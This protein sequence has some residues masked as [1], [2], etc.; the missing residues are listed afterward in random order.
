M[1]EHNN[2]EIGTFESD[3][4]VTIRKLLYNNNKNI[5]FHDV[6]QGI[7]QTDKPYVLRRYGYYP[8]LTPQNNAGTYAIV[9]RD[10]RD[11]QKKRIE[12][13][14]DLD[15][16]NFRDRV[17]E[18]IKQNAQKLP[19]EAKYNIEGLN[20]ANV[21]MRPVYGFKFTAFDHDGYT[22][23]IEVTETRNFLATTQGHHSITLYLEVDAKDADYIIKNPQE[24]K[25]V[26]EYSTYIVQQDQN[27]TTASI[28]DITKSNIYADLQQQASGK[29]I[30]RKDVRKLL[31]TLMTEVRIYS[32]IDRPDQYQNAGN[33][34]IERLFTIFDQKSEQMEANAQA[35]LQKDKLSEKDLQADVLTGEVHKTENTSKKSGGF[36]F[37]SKIINNVTSIIPVV[38]VAK[39]VSNLTNKFDETNE[40]DK[41]GDFSSEE[42]NKKEISWTGEKISPKDIVLVND[43]LSAMEQNLSLS[44]T[45]VFNTRANTANTHTIDFKNYDYTPKKETPQAPPPPTIITETINGISI[46]LIRAEGGTF[47]MGGQDDQVQ[48]NEKPA[49]EVTLNTFY[50]GKYPVTQAQWRAVMNTNPSYFKGDNLPVENVSWEDAVEFCHRLSQLTGKNYRLSTEAEWEYAARGG[51]KS[52]S[53]KYA[54]SN[55]LDTVAWYEQKG[56]ATTRPV[57]QKNPNELG[58]YDMSGNVWEWCQDWYD[59]DYYK[60]SPKENPKGAH[61]GT[62]RVLRGGSWFNRAIGCRVA[63]RDHDAPGNRG[64]DRGFRIVLVP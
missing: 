39:V 48:E 41:K 7:H 51:N 26:C 34:L 15:N 21:K 60:N 32:E 13:V 10:A 37:L 4:V 44:H 56:G 61:S 24:I 28:S 55:N 22:Y 18:E 40:N 58:L 20:K 6:F 52:R 25:I 64:Y 3:A 59:A 38:K 35:Y 45:V 17:F 2:P 31:N 50:I 23:P 63:L 53:Y 8:I 5:P 33:G 49:H 19:D 57:G 16:E 47:L 46:E 27:K 29:F 30:K 1:P 9:C 62:Y 14:I 54:G 11:P 42:T 43:L 36:S 12:I